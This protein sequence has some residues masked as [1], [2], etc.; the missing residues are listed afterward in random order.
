MQRPNPNEQTSSRRSDS[1]RATRRE[2]N[3]PKSAESSLRCWSTTRTTTWPA[4]PKTHAHTLIFPPPPLNTT[5]TITFG[6]IQNID[7]LTHSLL[8]TDY[9]QV[10]GTSWSS[11]QSSFKCSLVVGKLYKIDNW[12]ACFLTKGST[13]VGGHVCSAAK[14]MICES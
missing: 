5:T 1:F 14:T 12:S 7:S 2:G 8:E 9:S 3:K 11:F 4:C 10:F 13:K 6:H